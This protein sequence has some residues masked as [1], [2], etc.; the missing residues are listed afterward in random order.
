MK[1]GFLC[2]VLFVNSPLFSCQQELLENVLKP[3]NQSKVLFRFDQRSPE[4]I[5][6]NGGFK[7]W[8]TNRDLHQHADGSSIVAKTS[9]FV[10]TS[11]SEVE[12]LYF[13]KGV[14]K[15]YLYQILDDG[16]GVDLSYSSLNLFAYEQEVT[17]EDHVE[18][19]QII[20]FVETNTKE[21]GFLFFKPKL[22]SV[23]DFHT[24]EEIVKR[25]APSLTQ[26][27]RSPPIE[28]NFSLN[29]FE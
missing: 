1:T 18:T 13:S 5:K 29:T 16:R 7:A 8:G 24:G 27:L 17:F 26:K 10:S 20:S 21:S 19:K 15:G 25:E 14:E 28:T 4:E 9:A 22:S 11:K 6:Q 2:F 3:E 23:Y 12:S